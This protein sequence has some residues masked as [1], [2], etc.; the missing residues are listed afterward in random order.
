MSQIWELRSYLLHVLLY[1][2]TLEAS[3]IYNFQIIVE[4]QGRSCFGGGLFDRKGIVSNA[5][6]DG[7]Q[8]EN[9][10]ISPIKLDSIDEVVGALESDHH[11]WDSMW[12]EEDVR[13][14]VFWRGSFKT[15]CENG[16][17]TFLKLDGWTKGVAWINGFNLGRY[18]PAMGP[19]KTLYVP[20]PVVKGRRCGEEGDGDNEII[21]LEQDWA[22]CTKEGKFENCLVEFVDTPEID[23][24]TPRA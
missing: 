7:W 21:L 16:R 17:D 1:T 18:W 3:Y 19:Q 4:N 15:T 22:G 9:W 2:G 8:L 12:K 6:L 5:T 24:E 23:G 11:M 14:M 20:G 10:K 13:R